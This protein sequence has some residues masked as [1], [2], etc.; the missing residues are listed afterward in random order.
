MKKG[1]IRYKSLRLTVVLFLLG[2]LSRHLQAEEIVI[3]IAYPLRETAAADGWDV[4][5]LNTARNVEYLSDTEKDVMLELNMVRHD[6]GKYAELYVKPLEGERNNILFSKEPRALGE[7]YRELLKTRSIHILRP[8]EG[9]SR[10]A[11]DHVADQ[12]KK[13]RTGHSGSDGSNPNRRCLRYGTGSMVGGENISYGLSYSRYIMLSL[14]ID[15][16]VSSRGHRKNIL[17]LDYYYAGISVGPHSRYGTMCVQDFAGAYVTKDSAEEEDEL[18]QLSERMDSIRID[19]DAENW[20]IASLD[21]AAEADYLSAVEKDLILE[22][23]K[24]RTDPKKYAELYIDP[25]DP[26]YGIIARMKALSPL[27]PE[28]GLCLVAG[29]SQGSFNARLRRY[30]SLT[31]RT[32]ECYSAGYFENGRELLISVLRQANSRGIVVNGQNRLIGL[33]VSGLQGTLVCSSGYTK[34]ANKDN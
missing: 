33:K 32:S 6:P 21:A 12:G 27:R 4:E 34:F 29:D 31:G 9:L 17:D 1:F 22:M 2:C 5:Y 28:E 24:F 16:G 25:E 20:D 7:C 13:G 10:A 8:R 26:L 3:M 11:A 19:P 30:G 23:N 18:R 14:L 15:A